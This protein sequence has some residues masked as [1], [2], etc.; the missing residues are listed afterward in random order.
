[1][2][3]ILYHG[4]PN[5]PS[6]AVLAAAFETGVQVALRRIDLAA[7]ERHGGIP[8]AQAPELDYSVE[9]EG[10]VLVV[11]GVAMTDSVFL[12][13]YLD[14]VAGGAILRPAD[15][16]ARWQVMAWCRWLVERVAPA[17]AYLGTAAMPPRTVPVG[18]ANADLAERWEQAVTGRCDAALLADSRA[19]TAAGVTR[20]EAQ[21]ADGRDWLFG[22]IGL[23]DF[24]TYG[25]LCGMAPLAAEALV[26]RPRTAAWLARVKAHP[27]VARALALATVPEPE[28]VWA[29]GPEINRWG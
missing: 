7:G 23:A 9:G 15:P 28:K 10:P 20:V 21:L 8:G 27:S 11:D 22:A 16:Y 12:A 19:K 3:A 13:C 29:P 6:L 25:W 2:N 26:G 18:I 24:E 14:D 4:E 17:A 1:M 5:G